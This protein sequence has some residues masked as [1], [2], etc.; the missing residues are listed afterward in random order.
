MALAWHL[1]LALAVVTV[2]GRALGR[3]CAA[4]GQ[5]P[6]IGEVLAG[7]F[8]GP[9]LLGKVAPE[10]ASYLF[11]PA[12]VP[13]LGVLAQVGVVIYMFLIGLELDLQSITRQLRTTLVTSGAGIV[14]P[15][16]LGLVLAG[17]L[18]S[19]F[20]QPMVPFEHFTLFMG[21]ALSIT[22]FP[23][24]ARILSDQ[25]MT[26]TRLGALALTCAAVDDVTAWC[27]L[28]FVVGVV[29][30][31]GS[32]ALMVALLTA[33]FII[34]MFTV[35]RPWAERFARAA[36][37]N[38]GWPALLATLAAMG[39]SA[40]VTEMI[41]IHAIFGAF[42]L[43]AVIPHDSGVATV[44]RGGVARFL[45]ALLLPAFFAF[46]GLRTEIGLV[47]GTGAWL[48]VLLIITVA[49]VGKLGGASVA[50]RLMGLDSRQALGLGVLMNTRGLME[51][52]VLNVG[53]DLGV[54]SRTMFAMLVLMAI[55]TTVG[56]APLLAVVRPWRPAAAPSGGALLNTPR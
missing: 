35:V 3:V 7:I 33:A 39:A 47:A 43:A 22:A 15:F 52:I 38:P 36:G 29:R 21:I 25:G 6:V 37:S 1:A 27:L 4:V 51:L 31:T 16:A 11:P 56:T 10:A 44:L 23:V 17:F 5:P 32:S 45:A 53:L 18:H 12:I 19:R 30:G 50:A 49:T 24:L 54:I 28:A 2:A 14:V 40:F 13:S 20:G 8:L 46:T 48:T 55:A 26:T 42:L 34:T 41:G 9:S